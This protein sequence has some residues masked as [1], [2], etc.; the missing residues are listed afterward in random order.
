VK[1]LTEFRKQIRNIGP[2][3]R[4]WFTTFGLNLDL[5]ERYILP[6]LAGCD[7]PTTPQEFETLQAQIFG[8]DAESRLDLKVFYDIRTRPND[9][10]KR[11]SIPLYGVDF[12]TAILQ[13]D[14]A[15]FK[16]GFFH[17]KVIYL[18]GENGEVIGAGS[19]N[20]TLDGW[21]R[22]RECFHF[23][24]LKGKENRAEVT[25]FFRRIHHWCGIKGDLDM[26]AV[27]RDEQSNQ[28]WR[29]LSSVG[30]ESFL[31]HLC[32]GRDPGPLVV[33]T[34]FLAD[35]LAGLAKQIKQ[36]HLIDFLQVV[37]DR[38]PQGKIRLSHESAKLFQAAGGELWNDVEFDWHT[39]CSHAKVWM[40]RRNLAIGSWNLTG[41]ATGY[42]KFS[43]KQNVEAGF[44][45]MDQ[46][47]KMPAH[48][49][50]FNSR[51]VTQDSAV[52]EEEQEEWLA[53]M[54]PPKVPVS[55]TFD[56]SAREWSWQIPSEGPW[57]EFQPGL[58]LP[59]GNQGTMTVDLRDRP[60]SKQV[61]SDPGFLLR[62]RTVE[63]RHREDGNWHH[64][65]VWIVELNPEDR[66][67]SRFDSWEDLLAG[68][69]A[70]R[71]E[72]ESR[73]VRSLLDDDE[74]EALELTSDGK[75]PSDGMVPMVSYF[76]MFAAMKGARILLSKADSSKALL[77]R[78]SV[79]PGCLAE[80][81]EA[82]RRQLELRKDWSPVYRWFLTHEL[83]LLLSAGETRW[84][85]VAQGFPLP[86]VFEELRKR[87]PALP[88]LTGKDETV[89]RHLENAKKQAG[90]R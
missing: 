39:R 62:Q 57:M 83:H 53:S 50:P 7:T 55:V 71:P 18:E 56:W 13:A 77:R 52:L 16:N 73:G 61:V 34:P 17:P 90:Y 14:E 46:G 32:A 30:S 38:H 3:K 25:Q 75:R 63:A 42:S 27:R 51:E 65:T 12:R 84:G 24:R 72:S 66:P 36:D 22:N 49:I 45:F 60:D 74:V 80:I 33:W 10:V 40:T 1:I 58:V 89:M 69:I 44:V 37:P 28:R 20:L 19:A 15:R 76:R 54:E 6:A 4:A 88:V 21:A 43:G 9:K 29:F 48:I 70:G 85:N 2:I 11:T 64:V 78:I 87:L 81:L 35:D 79:Y 68:L 41:P 8:E 23:E 47:A 59:M 26:P 67:V 5:L 82:G 31:K 86:E